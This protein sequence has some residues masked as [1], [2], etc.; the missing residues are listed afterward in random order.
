MFNKKLVTSMLSVVTAA[1]ILA[2]CNV[3]AAD[4]S[5][6]DKGSA[7]IPIQNDSGSS[8]DVGS[9]YTVTLPATIDGFHLDEKTKAY[10]STNFGVEVKGS[11]LPTQELYVIPA[12]K[13]GTTIATAEAAETDAAN[14]ITKLVAGNYSNSNPN[15]TG[16]KLS[17]FDTYITNTTTKKNI[18]V[19]LSS[20]AV[21]FCNPDKTNIDT[22]NG[23]MELAMDG[24]YGSNVNLEIDKDDVTAGTYSGSVEMAW[25]LV[26]NLPTGDLDSDIIVRDDESNLLALVDTEEIANK[27]AT[28]C[29]VT[30]KS[31]SNGIATFTNNSGKT[32]DELNAIASK[33]GYP[34][35][36]INETKYA[37]GT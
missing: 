18:P 33:N 1:S 23:E 11:I 22:A 28:N 10:Y 21:A 25:G 7:S 5:Y 13:D 35:F 2:P 17:T 20:G 26:D 30:L 8:L 6:T 12:Y 37:S 24:N 31:Y 15:H 16:I 19:K 34:S 14:V 36:S 9:Y 32:L 29:G 3:F 4:K 27:M